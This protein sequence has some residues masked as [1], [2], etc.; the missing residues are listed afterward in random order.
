MATIDPQWL[1]E[2][3]LTAGPIGGAMICIY[4]VHTRLRSW[5]D[6][7][8]ESK[9]RESAR[10]ANRVYIGFWA[11]TLSLILVGS[12][13]TIYQQT[14]PVQTSN[15][16]GTISKL[17]STAEIA[18]FDGMFLRSSND[19]FNRKKIIFLIETGQLDA[20]DR[21]SF[22][23]RDS[24][25]RVPEW[26]LACELS[27][28]DAS[29][30][31]FRF[32]SEILDLRHDRDDDPQLGCER[33]DSDDPLEARAPVFEPDAATRWAW[34]SIAAHAEDGAAAWADIVAALSSKDSATQRDARAYLAENFTTFE[35]DAYRVI[36]DPNVGRDLWLNALWALSRRDP[37]DRPDLFAPVDWPEPVWQAV[38]KAALSASEE[39]SVIGRRIVASYPA[40]ETRKTVERIAVEAGYE[41]DEWYQSLLRH[42]DY[43]RAVLIALAIKDGREHPDPAEA[44]RG[45]DRIIK[46][47][48]GT[49]D[50]T[51]QLKAQYGMGFVLAVSAEAMPETFYP[52]D[53]QAE[54]QKFLDRAETEAT[55]YR[56]PSQ[57]RNAEGYLQKGYEVFQ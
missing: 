24:N 8:N 37:L 50:T 17:P 27:L 9:D 11:F 57:I 2:F 48:D 31:R 44:L 55:D 34:L 3:A 18:G 39:E 40:E 52:A 6:A 14:R 21:A 51:D 47:A 20:T 12:G 38:T 28:A 41:T 43:N 1:G 10:V 16:K 5:V 46:N 30:M 49:T 25:D 42:Y 33:L 13:F 56:Y 19:G 4:A 32:D 15:L 54:F 7:R 26:T 36:A 35:A 23:I 22:E 53:A 45:L 29:R